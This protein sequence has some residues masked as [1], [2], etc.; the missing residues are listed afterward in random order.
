MAEKDHSANPPHV[1]DKVVPD[2]M[3]DVVAMPADAE[4]TDVAGGIGHDVPGQSLTFD[5]AD[6]DDQLVLS[7]N[8]LLPDPNGD[9]VL[10]NDAGPVA[11]NIMTDVP[12]TETGTADHYVTS[13]G[14]DVSG[15][16]YCTFEAGVTIYYPPGMDL[17]VTAHG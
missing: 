2:V 4:F 3:A 10:F 16:H 8:D 17:L 9:V 6:V 12:I 13:S 15:Y 11:V 7:L 1:Q 5:S 14:V